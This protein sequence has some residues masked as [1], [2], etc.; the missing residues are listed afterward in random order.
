MGASQE[1]VAAVATPPGRGGIGIVRISGPLVTNI[2]RAVLG[3]TPP[4]RQAIHRTFTGADGE[5]IDDGI[6][7]FFPGPNSFTGE[8]VLELQGHGGPVVMDM[9]LG[10]ILELGA[11]SARPGE[12]SQRAFLND[13]IDLAQAEAIADLIDCTSVQAVRSARGSLQGHFSQCIESLVAHIVDLRTY[14]EAS[15]DFPDEEVDFLSDGQVQRRLEAIQRDL[16]DTFAS[17][18]QGCLLKEGLTIVIAGRPNVGKSSLLN[19]LTGRESAIVT[20]VPGT[21]R[22]LLRE[23]IQ[24]DGI[25]LHVVDT[26]GLR[27]TDDTIERLGIERAWDAINAADVI[28]LVLDDRV[29][30]TGPEETL[31]GQFRAEPPPIIVRNKIDLSHAAPTLGRGRFGLEVGVSAKTGAGIELLKQQLKDAV[32]YSQTTEGSFMARRRHLEALSDARAALD[33]AASQLSGE[34]AG[35]LLA[36]DLQQAHRALG[37][38]TGEFSTDDLLG[39]IF[40]SFCIGK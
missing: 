9:L 33:S 30:I 28:L 16:G 14:V 4:P 5:A 24:I 26:A 11:R 22:D 29:G 23:Y 38:I 32:G 21:T 34:P 18:Q 25:P 20:D 8:D 39:R 6:A 31:L 10:R 7:L 12:F 2:A 27:P 37:E 13:K 1:T 36:E 35:E 40:S 3:V 15:I 17:A 19:Q